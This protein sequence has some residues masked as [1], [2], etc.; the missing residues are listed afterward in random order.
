[1]IKVEN[2]SK[3]YKENN[4]LALDDIS[5][6]LQKGEFAA[7]LGPNG[8]GKTTL[9]NVISGV[10]VRDSGNVNIAGYD[11]DRN[12]VEMKTSIGIVPQEIAVDNFFTVREILNLQSGYYGMRRNG[13]YIAY[14]AERLSLSDKMN[15]VVRSLSGGMKRRLLIAKALLHKPKILILDEP[16]AGVDINL[17]HDLY[18]FVKEMNGDGMTIL[19]T[20]HYLEEAEELCSRIILIDEGR[21]ITD[22]PKKEF[23]KMAGDFLIVKLSVNFD[24]SKII[25]SSMIRE[26]K[27]SNK[28]LEVPK[29]KI[30]ELI[31][32]LSQIKDKIDDLNI[33]SPGVEELF[34]RLTEKGGKN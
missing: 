34:V 7:L 13:E 1:M 23:L 25:D 11:I 29:N 30:P 14:I 17:R 32:S 10:V 6:E 24:M 33:S 18:R 27:T 8:A 4:K 19:L 26:N 21:L 22:K 31:S 16:T 15:S 12:K 2:L 9:I 5:F 20:T 28:I 3:K